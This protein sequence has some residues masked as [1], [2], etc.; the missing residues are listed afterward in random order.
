MARYIEPVGEKMPMAI[1]PM[2]IFRLASDT[3][4]VRQGRHHWRWV[5]SKKSHRPGSEKGDP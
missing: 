5:L 2:S 4:N 3:R 1:N